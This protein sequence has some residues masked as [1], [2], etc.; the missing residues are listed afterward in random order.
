MPPSEISELLDHWG[1]GD[2]E[3]LKELLPLIYDDL[4]ARARIRLKNERS[5]IS[6]QGTDLVHELYFDLEKMQPMNLNRGQFFAFAVN[7]MRHILVDHARHKFREKRGGRMIR[8][9]LDD[10]ENGVGNQEMSFYLLPLSDAL[11]E[12]EKTNP[13]QAQIV[14]LKCF[15]GYSIEEIAKIVGKAPATIKRDWHDALHWLR[16]RLEN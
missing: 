11:N 14:E 12:L 3:A 6:W 2:R 16:A 10:I 4:R 8:V 1:K 13:R 5:D 9:S 15:G 7:R